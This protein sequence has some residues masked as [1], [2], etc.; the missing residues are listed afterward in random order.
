MN[1]IGSSKMFTDFKNGGNNPFPDQDKIL[2]TRGNIFK[3][4]PVIIGP[5]R[6]FS[7]NQNTKIEE[8]IRS[9]IIRSQYIINQLTNA[10]VLED[11]KGMIN[12]FRIETRIQDLTNNSTINRQN[13]KITY[14]VVPYRVHISKLLP[15][16][17]I[18]PGYDNLKKTVNR[19][20]NYIYTGLNTEII[21][22]DL[23]FNM[24]FF[25]K[26]AADAGSRPGT[27][28]PGVTL[29]NPANPPKEKITTPTTGVVDPTGATVE[30]VAGKVRTDPSGSGD[31][32]T[33]QVQNYRDLL[34]NP[35]DLIEIKLTIRGDPYY[36]PSSGMGN[37]IGTP[38]GDNLMSDG[39]MNYQNGEVDIVLNFRT[40]IDLN[41]V[42]GLYTFSAVVDQFSG[43]YQIFEVESKFN[44]NKF[45]QTITAQRRRTQLIGSANRAVILSQATG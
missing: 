35:V 11:P 2:D 14:R 45:T 5:D 4:S 37:Q 16:N 21:S 39:S 29:D 1:E 18:P 31:A 23:D 8:I 3:Q 12:W 25:S 32:K 41:P 38:V 22:V 26:V 28:N 44:Q 34:T 27:S 15:P 13:R 33:A 42:T 36:L 10:T 6:E 20:Y 7:Y 19:I 9:V 43:L 24:A 30:T 17:T 40:P